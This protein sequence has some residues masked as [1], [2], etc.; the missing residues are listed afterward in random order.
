MLV[1]IL[2]EA[3][4]KKG[5]SEQK[6]W[7]REKPIRHNGEEAKWPNDDAELY[8][9]FMLLENSDSQETHPNF[10]FQEMAYYKE[11]PFPLDLELVTKTLVYLW[12][13]QT[14]TTY[15]HFCVIN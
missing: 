5:L 10:V 6:L 7:L 4:S 9:S 3:D 1:Q 14:Q 11:P 2:Q 8:L 12:Q 15:S 13:S